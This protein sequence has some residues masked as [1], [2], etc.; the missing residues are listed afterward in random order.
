MI[1]NSFHR[2]RALSLAILIFLFL[3]IFKIPSLQAQVTLGARS[4]ALGQATTALPNSQWSVF[5]NPAMISGQQPSVSFFGIRYYGLAELTDIAAVVSYPTKAGVIGGGAHRYGDD[6]YNESRLRLVYKNSYQDFHYGAAV[7]YN[8][9]A[10]G[11][12]YG[13][14]GALGID[15]GIAARISRGLWI[16]A[17]A[18]NINQPQYGQ[19]ND[20]EENLPRNLSI[21]F[22]YRLTRGA[23]L[24]TDVVK[25]VNFPISYR[26]G[27]EV[28]VIDNLQARA[29]ITT[30]PQT[31]SGGFGY[32]TPLWGV[33]LVVQ[34]H[35][36]RALGYSPGLDFN[37]SW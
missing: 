7:N 26:G 2:S 29:G 18:T 25:D 17:K 11:G 12:G 27:I 30:A 4:I 20:I 37:I 6:L 13:S 14:V 32:N 9:V 28:E 19:I 3:L 21:G 24:T 1:Q 10:Q 33:N 35:E 34:K 15:A 31:F 23:L 8:H 16:G 5:Q 22:S 36:T